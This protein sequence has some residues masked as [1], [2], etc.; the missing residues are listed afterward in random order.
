[1]L[2]LGVVHKMNHLRKPYVRR[3]VVSA[4]VRDRRNARA[5]ER[6]LA[7]ENKQAR[8]L[9]GDEIWP[10][11]VKHRVKHPIERKANKR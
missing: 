8:W 2:R 7:L 9:P 1:M 4:E 6:F 5:A 11:R 10:P 3:A